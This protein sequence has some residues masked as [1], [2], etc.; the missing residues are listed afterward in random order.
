MS[1]AFSKG[2]IFVFALLSDEDAKA[3]VIEAK[4]ASTS[5]LQRKLRVG[6][7]RAARLMDILEK[8]GIIGPSDGAKPREILIGNSEVTDQSNGSNSENTSEYP[9]NS[10]N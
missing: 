3:A 8:R 10:D 2:L 6:Y 5:Y 9:E 1:V 7:S 4:K